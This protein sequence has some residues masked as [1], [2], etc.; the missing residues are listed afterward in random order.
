ML[1]AITLLVSAAFLIVSLAACSG[2]A[3]LSTVQGEQTPDRATTQLAS[4]CR[5]VRHT[6]GETEICGR[7]EKIVALSPYT[8]EPIL[9]LGLQPAGFANHAPFTG[10]QYDRPAQQIPYLGDRVTTQPANVGTAYEPSIEAILEIQPDLIVGNKWLRE[11]ETLSSIAPTIFLKSSDVEAN[12]RAI[13]QAVGQPEKAE[14]LIASI[15]QRIADSRQDFAAIVAERPQLLVLASSDT[16]EFQV[17]RPSENLCGFLPSELGFQIVSP[18][19]TEQSKSGRTGW[20]GATPIS[21][22]TLPQLDEADAIVLLGSDSKTLNQFEDLDRFKQDQ[23][24]ALKETWEKNAIAQSLKASREG[25]VY[26]IP[27]YLCLGLPGP[28]GTELYLNELREQMLP[29]P[30]AAEQ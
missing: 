20:Q 10:K 3:G 6:A 11:Y 28:I 26:Y 19:E 17:F 16:R 18:L 21:L 24:A 15:Q 5:T 4:N 2:G 27:T 22:E 29:A 12:L 7:P 13:A 9:A 14:E 8:L 1:T 30:E 25:R 23:T